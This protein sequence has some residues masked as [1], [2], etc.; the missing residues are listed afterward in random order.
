MKKQNIMPSLVLGSICLVAAFLL[1]F[2][3]MVTDPII[4][5]AQ[6]LAANEALLVVLPEGSNFEEITIDDQYPSVID[7]GYKADGGYVFRANVTGKSSGLVIM[8]GIDENGKIVGTD[9]IAEQETDSY[10]VN[11][12]PKVEGTDGAYNGMALDSFEPYLVSGATLTSAAYADAVKAALQ[13]FV[14]A[15]GGEVDVR[16]PEQILQDNCNA[17]LGVEGVVFEKWFAT[18]V[19]EG[20]DAVYV[21]EDGSG[22]V[23]VIGESFVGVK[24]GGAIVNIGSADAMIVAFANDKI[25]S[26]NLKEVTELPEGINRKTIT[27]VYITDSGNYVFDV[28]AKGYQALFDY[29]NGATINIRLSISADGKIIDCLTVSHE[30]SKGYGD[31]CATEDYYAQYRGASKDDINVTVKSPDA[32]ADQISPDNTDVGVI[33]SATF[34]TYGYQKAV[35]AAFDAYEILTGGEAND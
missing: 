1:S 5:E 23:Y 25:S 7:K 31:V 34:T 13:A 11:V 24:A 21:A 15:N 9:V 35:K 17:A 8:I 4:K 29:G 14:I 28:V 26:S 30:E 12:F 22:R 19:L 18:E 10:D 20:V 6:N 2:V 3:N 32:H 33:A 16:T 27:K